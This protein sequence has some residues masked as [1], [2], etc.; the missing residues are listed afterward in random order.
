VIGRVSKEVAEA[1]LNFIANN[2]RFEQASNDAVS[3]AG[4][5][6]KKAI[7]RFIETADFDSPGIGLT[8]DEAVREA[9][10]TY[11]QP[12][13][14]SA[15]ALLSRYA[16]QRDN[17]IVDEFSSRVSNYSPTDELR[18]APEY[19][20]RPAPSMDE[21][22][23]SLGS[24]S[25][26]S[27]RNEMRDVQDDIDIEAMMNWVPDRRLFRRQQLS[28]YPEASSRQRAALSKN[29]VLRELLMDAAEG[30]PN[31]ASIIANYLDLGDVL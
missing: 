4:G 22:E 23:T 31:M 29:Y 6:R 27:F 30:D 10:S 28:E 11:G 26:S 1:A 21:Y 14:E 7:D 20:N 25:P 8:I 15:E 5:D 9:A 24:V 12:L 17:S 13:S 2:R 19:R 3:W 18:L 16:R